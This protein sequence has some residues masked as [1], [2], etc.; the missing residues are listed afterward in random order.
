MIHRKPLILSS[1]K[2]FRH[3]HWGS[4]MIWSP[5]LWEPPEVDLIPPSCWSV[6]FILVFNCS[7]LNVFQEVSRSLCQYFWMYYLVRLVL[8]NAHA[9]PF[10]DYKV[11]VAPG[12][13]QALGS[14][15]IICVVTNDVLPALSL[16]YEKPEADLLQRKPRDRGADRLANSRL[17]CHAYFFLGILETL[18]AMT[19][20]ASFHFH[21]LLLD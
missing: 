6:H 17:L 21:V 16:V 20:F 4:N 11:T 13:P 10:S 14:M 9:M 1:L 5:M 2:N 8:S 12:L 18:T 19:G 7:A 15:I 3:H